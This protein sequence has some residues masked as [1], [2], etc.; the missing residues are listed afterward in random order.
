MKNRIAVAKIVGTAALTLVLCGNASAQSSDALLDKLV[1]KGILTTKEAN[2]LRE[3]TDKGFNQ[4]YSA[5]SGLPDW[6]HSLKFN[7]DLRLRY[8]GIYNS[9]PSFNDRDRYRYR[10]RI[11]ATAMLTDHFETGL[12][13]MSG[14]NAKGGYSTGDPISGNASFQ[15]NA[16]K[17]LVYLDLAYMKWSPINTPDWSGSFTGGKMENPFVFSDMIFDP[18][19]TPEG[20]GEQFAFALDDQ[21]SFKFN[22]GE[23]VLD[24]SSTSSK[25]PFL[26]GAQVRLDS[27]WSPKWQSSFGISGLM[28]SGSKNLNSS[29]VPDQNKGNTRVNMNAGTTN[30][31]VYQALANNFNPVVV[32]GA[33]I[34][35]MEKFPMYVGA[36]PIRLGAD[37]AYN[38]AAD[39]NNQAFS[40]G[41]TF[42][43]SGKKG[44]WDFTYK[45]KYMESDFW[46]EE[47][48][49]SDTGGFY[50][51]GTAQSG[52]ATGYQPGTN[53]RGHYIRAAYSPY[54][55]FTLSVNY[56]L[57]D[58]I[59]GETKDSQ[60][61]RLQVDATLKF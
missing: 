1:E 37:Y 46:Y 39:G 11:G 60:T 57:F 6:V 48:V 21:N 51:T 20:L 53:L 56:F 8:D 61:G 14:E 28:I 52:G 10:L 31:P 30:K 18:D 7:G 19:Y 55:F 25:D 23:F 44:T 22:F 47:L 3:E 49:D 36:F 38:P 26:L 17:K 42:G 27:I 12:R 43:K 16:S 9:D 15:D 35:T 41:V 4:A 50:K 59:E 33:V 58:L 13:L 29:D 34:F 5:K 40:A 2:E 54:D 32:D 45:Y 24:E